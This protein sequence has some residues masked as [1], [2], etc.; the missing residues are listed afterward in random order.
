MYS[1]TY[2]I[3]ELVWYI[4]IYIYIYIKKISGSRIKMLQDNVEH[5]VNIR[6]Y[7]GYKIS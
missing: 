1:T 4:Y 5:N 3:H 2:L 7:F 6:S